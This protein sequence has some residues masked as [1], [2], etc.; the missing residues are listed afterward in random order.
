MAELQVATRSPAALEAVH[1]FGHE[2]LSHGCRTSAIFEALAVDPECAAA[3]AY[4]GALFLS[5][6]T[7]EGLAQAL[8]HIRLAETLAPGTSE[9]ERQLISAIASWAA[10]DPCEAARRLGE[11]VERWP[12]DVVSAKLCQILQIATGDVRAMVRTASLAAAADPGGYAAGLLAFALDQAGETD[13][14]ETLARRAIDRNPLADPWAQHAMAHV[15]C[16]R[17]DW[18][19][20]RAFLR[21]HAATWTRCSSFMLTHN[22]WHAALFALWLGDHGDALRLFDEQVWGVRKGHAQDQIN[23]ISLLARLEMRGVDAGS[24][25]EDIAGHVAPHACDA[26][27]GFAD[28]HYLYALTRA[29]R[30]ALVEEVLR[31]S[32]QTG[33]P[34]AD[35]ACG[36]VAHA[37]GQWYEAAV[38]LGQQRHRR[39]EI[40][41]SQVQRQW[42]DELLV[43]SLT[44]SRGEVRACA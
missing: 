27:S 23:A 42:F 22:W 40:G 24:R 15:H 16:A 18:I 25:W 30:D 41:G 31:A 21:G 35:L 2:L 29:G 20:G 33:S 34:L 17:E 26:L 10:G 38:A 9:R 32:G 3:H 28:L 19:E 1:R 7:R 13:R 4:A 8:P 36:T 6:T 12:H 43:D 37:R 39:R 14:A 5:L 44:R 11:L